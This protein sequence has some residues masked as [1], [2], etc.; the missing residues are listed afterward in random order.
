MV[1][2]STGNS[3]SAA[4]QRTEERRLQRA[5]SVKGSSPSPSSRP[6]TAPEVN[7]ADKK[8]REACVRKT[9]RPLSSSSSSNNNNNGRGARIEKLRDRVN[10]ES[11]KDLQP[12]E[13]NL[14]EHKGETF[15]AAPTDMRPQQDSMNVVALLSPVQRER[16][17]QTPAMR[18]RTRISPYM[19][20]RL[21]WVRPARQSWNQS[22]QPVKDS[23]FRSDYMRVF[24]QK[25]RPRSFKERRER[26]A[27]AT[28]AEG[29][30]QCIGAATL[31]SKDLKQ[32]W[33]RTTRPSTFVSAT[34]RLKGTRAKYGYGT[35]PEP[36]GGYDLGR[37]LHHSD[38]LSYLMGDSSGRSSARGGVDIAAADVDERGVVVD[39]YLVQRFVENGP[40]L[41]VGGE[42]GLRRAG[43]GKSSAR[44]LP[45]APRGTF[46]VSQKAAF[47]PDRI[48][49]EHVRRFRGSLGR[50][51]PCLVSCEKVN[52]PLFSVCFVFCHSFIL[53]FIL[54]C[55]LFVF[56]FFFL[57][58]SL[59]LSLFCS[60]SFHHYFNT[61]INT[62]T[63]PPLPFLLLLLLLLPS[64]RHLV[65]SQQVEVART[66]KGKEGG[67]R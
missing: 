37:T 67:T 32:S 1:R 30:G 56:F 40:D 11:K 47:V 34:Q 63:L 14:D 38:K 35:A 50:H 24:P 55:I 66:K 21:H 26:T 6:S 13:V 23:D 51:R 4:R 8:V 62:S 46:S 16:L 53:S 5:G 61:S 57:F 31:S 22:T 43:K 29:Y 59:F 44:L 2:K 41:F 60:S 65:I 45:A 10:K 49:R 54:S 27:R 18:G 7:I 15:I 19:A 28:S 17:Y 9:R 12:L 20:Q 3:E 39:E 48:E 33:T 58:L 64:R 42:G 36:A 25:V 52:F